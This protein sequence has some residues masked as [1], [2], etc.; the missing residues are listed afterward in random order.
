MWSTLEEEGKPWIVDSV[1]GPKFEYKYILH[2]AISSY[3]LT[4]WRLA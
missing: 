4:L 2:Q 1:Q 3:T